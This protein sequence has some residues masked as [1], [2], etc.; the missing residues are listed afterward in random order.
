L[1]YNI[2]VLKVGIIG[3]DYILKNE[4]KINEKRN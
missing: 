1:F 2:A 4:E 3:N